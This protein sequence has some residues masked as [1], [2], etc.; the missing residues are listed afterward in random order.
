MVTNSWPAL[1]V[2]QVLM[3]LK[4][5][6]RGN[7]VVLVTSMW[8]RVR[9]PEFRDST[10]IALQLF[11]SA[12]LIYNNLIYVYVVPPI[13]C[14]EVT[15]TAVPLDLG[16]HALEGIDVYKCFLLSRHGGTLDSHR[17]ASPFVRLGNGGE[18]WETPDYL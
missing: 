4:T 9:S 11:R 3:P 13:Q 1:F 14:S 17:A 15:L 18:R 7:L 6:G 2:P 16:A 5:R 10:P 8:L 12:T